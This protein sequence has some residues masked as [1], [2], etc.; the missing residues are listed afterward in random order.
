M[1]EKNHFKLSV[2]SVFD[3]DVESNEFVEL[4]VEFRY[5][6]LL[7]NLNEDCELPSKR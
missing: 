4:P 1:K 2:E 3:I 5:Q 7:I 6:M